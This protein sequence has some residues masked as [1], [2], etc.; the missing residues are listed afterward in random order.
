[1][2]DAPIEGKFIHSFNVW[3][4]ACQARDRAKGV[5]VTD[6]DKPTVDAVAALLLA[7]AAIEGFINEVVGDRDVRAIPM[8]VARTGGYERHVEASRLV[9]MIERSRGSTELKYLLASQV[10][11]GRMFDRGSGP[12][13]DVAMLFDL[14]NMIMH[15]KYVEQS[16]KILDGNRVSSE[17]PPKIRALQAR[18][19]ARR[20]AVGTWFQALQTYEIAAWACETARGIMRATIA[21]LPPGFHQKVFTAFM[22]QSEVRSSKEGS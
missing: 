14:R 6:P 18:G 15:L 7:A 2:S 22:E 4:L 5:A 19:L 8:E 1:M 10:L 3:E 16:V 20:T 17:M 12:F 21:M 9:E 11:S 13:Q